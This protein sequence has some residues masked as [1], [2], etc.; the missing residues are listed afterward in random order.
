MNIDITAETL[1]KQLK[2][3]VNEGSLKQ[4]DAIMN[5]TPNALKFFKHIFS[6][7]DTLAHVDAFI[8]PSSSCDFLKIKYHGNGNDEQKA[9]FHETVNHWA[10][11]Y[12]VTL[13]KLD[14]KD[15]FYIK[16]II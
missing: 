14:N 7:N 15:V 13:E 2:I 3:D 9:E 4:M 6:L 1:L 12:K 10:D 11:K 16:G 8:A 5:N